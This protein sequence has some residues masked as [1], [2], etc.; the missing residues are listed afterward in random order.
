LVDGL[1]GVAILKPDKMDKLDKSCAKLVW[2]SQD[3]KAG[4]EK[5]KYTTS[6]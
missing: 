3:E 5:A 2:Y 4:G 1:E 6:R